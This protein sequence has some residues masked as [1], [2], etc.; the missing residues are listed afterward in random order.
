MLHSTNNASAIDGIPTSTV[1]FAQV[2]R[3]G[4]ARVQHARQILPR[5]ISLLHHARL[6]MVQHQPA[7]ASKLVQPQAEHPGHSG[8]LKAWGDKGEACTPGTMRSAT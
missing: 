7:R 5:M 1:A 3:E 6:S 2:G 8:L 4:G